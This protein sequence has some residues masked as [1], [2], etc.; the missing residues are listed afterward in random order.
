MKTQQGISLIELMI[1]LGLGIIVLFAVTVIF[2][3][4]S[5]S[6]TEMEKSNRQTENGRYATQLL[7]NNLRMAGYLAE[8]DPTPLTIDTL[9]ALPDPCATATSDLIDALPLHV[10]GL[11]DG[12]VAP[13]CLSD[14]K[15]GTD[16]IV[17]RRASSCVA[18]TAN[19]DAFANG[20]PHL[21]ASLCAPAAGG[22]QLGYPVASN[23]DYAAHYFALSTSASDLTRQKSDCTTTADIYRYRVDIYF[24]ANNNE[25]GDGIPTLKRAELGS[26]GFSIVPLVDGVDNMQIDYG[27]DNDNDGTADV[28]TADPGAYGGCAGNACVANWRNTMSARI[29]LLVKNI[30]SS[31]GHTDNRIYGLGLNAD[32]SAKTVGPFGD[33]YKRHVYTTTSRFANP[34]WRRQ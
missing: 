14:R 3:N 13:A 8:F 15:S 21:Q 27:I 28:Y 1:A 31:A 23:A 22:T 26:G 25:A 11:N 34:A 16:I 30:D 24:I 17:V 5:G 29:H 9:V 4:T 18:G 32:G 6:R 19:C 33:A 20:T 12:A 7:A 10:Q 2:A